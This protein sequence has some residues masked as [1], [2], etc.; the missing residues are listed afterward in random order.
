[1]AT[2]R[3]KRTK[4]EIDLCPPLRRQTNN[5]I[6]CKQTQEIEPSSLDMDILPLLMLNLHECASLTKKTFIIADNPALLITL[7]NLIPRQSWDQI[8]L[9]SH[10]SLPCSPVILKILYQPS[11]N[12]LV[13][14]PIR[15]QI[16]SIRWEE[17]FR[18]YIPLFHACMMVEYRV[19]NHTGL[20]SE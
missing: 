16:P 9:S 8:F 13:R 3:W 1:M 18:T 12:I 2:I 11:E 6:F 17:V 20:E 14:H 7:P 15:N 5:E 4:A 10:R 19:S